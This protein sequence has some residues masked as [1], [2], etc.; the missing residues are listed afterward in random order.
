MMQNVYMWA[1]YTH[2]YVAICAQQPATSLPLTKI[3]CSLKWTSSSNII[4]QLGL[5]KYSYHLIGNS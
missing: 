5:Q 3:F 1:V 2:T 4:L